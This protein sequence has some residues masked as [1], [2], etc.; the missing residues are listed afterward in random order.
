MTPPP[1][2]S[3]YKSSWVKIDGINF[4]SIAEGE[5]YKTLRD[6][7]H[8]GFISHLELQPVFEIRHPLT[9]ELACRYKGDFRY[10][11]EKGVVVEDVKGMKTETYA[12]KKKL[13]RIFCEVN[14]TEISWRV[15]TRNKVIVAYRWFINGVEEQA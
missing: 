13:V 14:I 2:Q 3:K 8:Q 4:Q 5:R 15:R 7:E 11:S 9:N 10:R 1:R 6:R 12:L